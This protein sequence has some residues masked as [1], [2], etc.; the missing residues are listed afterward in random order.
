MTML[1]LCIAVLRSIRV[2][3]LGLCLRVIVN[4]KKTLNL[5]KT[6]SSVLSVLFSIY[7]YNHKLFCCYYRCTGEMIPNHGS[8]S[9]RRK[10]STIVINALLH[11]F[12]IRVSYPHYCYRT[13]SSLPNPGRSKYVFTHT[14]SYKHYPLYRTMV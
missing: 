3:P 2:T 6:T 8:V 4:E 13:L 11:Y 12:F 14:H 7:V 10:V 1:S 9:W 5:I